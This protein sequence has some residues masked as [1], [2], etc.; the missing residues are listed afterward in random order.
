MS[1][2]PIDILIVEDEPAHAEA[3]RRALHDAETAIDVRIA[4]SLRE[5]R[6]AVAVRKPNLVLL[7]FLLPDGQ[8][9]VELVAP[10]EAGMFPMVLM[11]SH[12]NEQV[13]VSAIRQG[14]LDYVVKSPEAFANMPQTVERTLRAWHTLKESRLGAGNARDEG[15]DLLSHYRPGKGCHRHL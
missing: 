4:G 14:A 13:A 1:T 11:T 8:A 7:D 5:F 2:Q 12:G 15:G 6:Q 3:I 9:D 10:P